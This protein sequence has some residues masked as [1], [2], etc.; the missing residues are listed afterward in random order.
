MIKGVS[1]ENPVCGADSDSVGQPELA[2]S[3]TSSPPIEQETALIIKGLHV[4]EERVH[5]I[6]TPGAI[7]R[8]PLGTSE[9]AGG[10]ARAADNAEEFSS[11]I[12]DLNAGIHGV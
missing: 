12:E 4:I 9:M 1:H 10:V 2:R 3:G 8:R 11:S 7:D 5:H 6:D